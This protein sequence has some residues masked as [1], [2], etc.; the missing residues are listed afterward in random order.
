MSRERAG[1]EVGKLRREAEDEEELLKLLQSDHD[2]DDGLTD[3][4]DGEQTGSSSDSESSC[5]AETANAMQT[6]MG[7]LR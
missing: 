7:D 2:D 3:D 4:Y 1:W 6:T 5:D